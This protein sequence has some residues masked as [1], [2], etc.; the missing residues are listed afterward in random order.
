MS[1]LFV[2][3]VAVL[4]LVIAFSVAARTLRRYELDRFL[5]AI[6]RARDEI[7]D[8]LLDGR[9]EA[10]EDVLEYLRLLP[11]LAS[12]TDLLTPYQLLSASRLLKRGGWRPPQHR[13]L[14]RRPD[15]RELLTRVTTDADRAK[16]RFVFF[17][18]PSGWALL[19]ASPLISLFVAARSA[20]VQAAEKSVRLDQ[21]QKVAVWSE[22]KFGSA[23]DIAIDVAQTRLREP[24]FA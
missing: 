24:A 18:S 13:L 15:E 2:A 19:A 9:V 17:G 23:S 6:R 5:S 11:V 8:A 14:G 12:A 1:S 22:A 16:E 3:T 21:R 4:N 7:V 20:I 10:N